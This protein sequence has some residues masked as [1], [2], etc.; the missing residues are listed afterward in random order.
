MSSYPIAEQ[1]LKKLEKALKEEDMVLSVRETYPLTLIISRNQAP[2]AQMSFL[3]MT[4]GEDSSPD[5]SL[6]FIFFL[7][8]LVIQT[9][10]RVRMSADFINKLKGLAKKWH[11]D[12]THGFFAEKM[13]EMERLNAPKLETLAE[14][15]AEETTADAFA[16]FMDEGDAS[17]LLDDE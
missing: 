1:H 6:R 10:K 15:A 16:E 7:N 8:G 2:E 12:Y 5:F 9:N 4:N 14:T 17:G 11:V 13:M 3:D